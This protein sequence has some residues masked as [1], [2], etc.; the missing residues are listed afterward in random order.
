MARKPAGS[1]AKILPPEAA[2][3]WARSLQR[4]GKKVVFTNGCFDLIHAGHVSY[5]E[6]ARREGDALVVALNG[7]A[8]VRRLKGAGRPLNPLRDRARVMAALECVDAV[9]WFHAD[10]PLSTIRKILPDVLVKG[11][12]WPV[13]RIVGADIVLRRGGH[14]KS[15]DFVEGRSTTA[16]IRKAR[17]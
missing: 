12:D 13:D 3:R 17:R 9:T 11:G 6:K 10:T 8:S 16:I 5:L 7:D 14:V 4:R 1:E 2:A 15:L